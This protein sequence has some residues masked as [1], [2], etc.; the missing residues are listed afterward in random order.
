MGNIIFWVGFSLV[1]L[2]GY[3]IRMRIDSEFAAYHLRRV[4]LIWIFF[5]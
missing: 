2:I 1:D 3:I 4:P 5:N